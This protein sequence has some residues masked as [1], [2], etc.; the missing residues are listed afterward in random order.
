MIRKLLPLIIVFIATYL[1]S[2]I[3]KDLFD[4][5]TEWSSKDEKSSI[6]IMLKVGKLYI[7]EPPEDNPLLP[8]EKTD[9]VYSL[10]KAFW[11]RDISCLKSR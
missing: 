4:E 1:Y 6:K 8:S 9:K 5:V 3:S 2:E 10:C 7:S 11:A